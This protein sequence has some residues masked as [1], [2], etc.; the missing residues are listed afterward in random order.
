MIQLCQSTHGGS[1]YKR[2]RIYY[3]KK[4]IQPWLDP[5]LYLCV[6]HNSKKIL[7]FSLKIVD[8]FSFIQANENLILLEVR[9]K[10][11]W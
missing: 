1:K 3:S 9:Q 2:S 5:Q 11:F 6:D 7:Q 4:S 8:F 10:T